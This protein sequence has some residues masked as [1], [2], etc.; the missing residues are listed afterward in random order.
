M[1]RFAVNPIPVRDAITI[2]GRRVRIT[3]LDTPS[4]RIVTEARLGGKPKQILGAISRVLQKHVREIGEDGTARE[5]KPWDKAVLL[6]EE[7]D[8]LLLL[9]WVSY[10]DLLTLGFQCPACDTPHEGY[11]GRISMMRREMF[12]CGDPS[13][14]CH[15]INA[16]S[17]AQE[18]GAYNSWE[19]MKARW[20]DVPADHLTRNPEGMTYVPSEDRLSLHTHEEVEAFRGLEIGVKHLAMKAREDLLDD[21]KANESASDAVLIHCI[22]W[23]KWPSDNPAEAVDTKA[24][25]PVDAEKAIRDAV[26][27][28]VSLNLR[29]GIA[30][31]VEKKPGKVDAK[32]AV[33]CSVR[34]C[35]K[36]SVLPIRVD[37]SFLF[38]NH[39]AALKN[40]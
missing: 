6:A 8:M 18:G 38:P 37:E 19:H 35:S 7:A 22:D 12:E 34:L 11:Q 15:A 36:E 17:K 1:S 3:P 24:L 9:R 23:I 21:L 4:E 25:R 30:A 2:T 10:G 5:I 29:N 14:P 28:M 40:S 27:Q 20:G 32:A 39:A 31:F 16:E 13:C 26:R 33:Q